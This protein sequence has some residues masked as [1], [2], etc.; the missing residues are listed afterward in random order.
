MDIKRCGPRAHT[1]RGRS[2]WRAAA[3]WALPGVLGLAATT[4]TASIPA[5]PVMTLY[6]FNGD[7]E[8][9][10]YDVEQF[11]APAV[12]SPGRDAGP[13]HHADSLPASCG[14]AAGDR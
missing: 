4:A 11:R 7:I 5:T 13:G 12:R 8:L 10:Y 3:G 9:P 2:W 6:R 1:I 14:T